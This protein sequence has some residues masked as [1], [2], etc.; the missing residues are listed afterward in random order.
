MSRVFA[1]FTAHR[2]IHQ[3]SKV[4]EICLIYLLYVE[5]AADLSVSACSRVFPSDG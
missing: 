5:L 1:I 3:F 4:M 2:S